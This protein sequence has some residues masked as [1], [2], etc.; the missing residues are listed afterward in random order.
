[1]RSRSF[2]PNIWPGFVDALATLLMVLVFLLMMFVLSQFVLNDALFERDKSLALLNDELAGLSEELNLERVQRESLQ[3]ELLA[4]GNRFSALQEDLASKVAELAE[5]RTSV[6]ALEAL[7]DSLESDLLAQRELTEAEKR[8]L[9][10]AQAELA[11]LN[12]N[13]SALR[14]SLDELTETLALSEQLNRDKDIE[15]V[16][17]GKKL[18]TALAGRAQELVRYRS[19]F[20]GRLREVLSDRDD[21]EIVGDRFVFRSEVLFA[22]GSAEIT[23][24][25]REQLR[26]VAKAILEISERIPAE[27]DWVLRVD[28]HTDSLP[29]RSVRFPSNWELSSGR[30]ISVIRFFMD[31]GVMGERLVAAGFGE[32]R[33]LV[34]GVDELSH[35]RNRR[36]E[37]KLTL[38]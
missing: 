20:F 36:I 23:D 35:S 33:P 3:G 22:R 30:S 24:G 8:K 38:R 27:I 2:M 5:Y 13:I 11:L 28:G 21:I 31:E 18:N 29:I 9:L 37:L 32:H 25:G 7:R 34:E 19:E 17:L 6:E 26:S 14:Q 1:M 10:E 16:E 4:L 12:N 15:I